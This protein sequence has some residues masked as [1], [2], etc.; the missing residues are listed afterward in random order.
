MISK[1]FIYVAIVVIAVAIMY[2]GIRIAF[3]TFNP[4]YIVASGSM[5]PTL[6]ISDFVIINHN[7]PF[8][9]LKVGD[10]IVFKSPGSLIPNEQHETIV[11]RIVH[12]STGIEG[13]VITTK[14]DANDGSIP[15]IDYPLREQN[16]VGKVVYVIPKLGLV[17]KMLS[18]PTNYYIIIGVIMITVVYYSRI[19]RRE[20]QK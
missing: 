6:N 2:V 8:S 4:F 1:V 5:I 10:I 14:G 9:N 12:I 20:Q 13:R 3:G 7:I 16:Y 17:T 15:Y 18:P 19:G 11:H